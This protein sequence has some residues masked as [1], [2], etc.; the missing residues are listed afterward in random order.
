MDEDNE[1]LPNHLFISLRYE[2]NATRVIGQKL[3]PAKIKIKTDISTRGDDTDDYGLQMEVAL[4]KMSYWVSQ[5]LNNAIL[6]SV[7]NDWA[8]DSFMDGAMP[9]TNN[10]VMI[11]PE[12]PTDACLAEL[13]ICKF[14]AITK[15]AFEFHAIDVESSDGRG[16]GFT[17]VGG[18]P[19]ESFPEPEEWLTERNYFRNQWWNRSDAS[20]LD[21]V[22][23][24]DDDLNEVPN[25]A[26][27]LSFIEDQFVDSEAPT[28]NKVVRA[29]F[30]PQVIEGGKVD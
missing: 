8:L 6:V 24:D 1:T 25:W 13:L 5:I 7:E 22:P 27:S 3:S 14:K 19:G 21:V 2:F 28:S 11:C 29:E 18:R 26:Y 15:G 30:R 20:T 12:E 16:M 23:D 9:T 17:F 10:S 4:A